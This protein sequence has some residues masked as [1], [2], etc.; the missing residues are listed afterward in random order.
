[1]VYLNCSRFEKRHIIAK[2]HKH[3]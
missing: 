1:M 2:T 3:I